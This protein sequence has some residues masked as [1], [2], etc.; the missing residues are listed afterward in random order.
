MLQYLICILN[1]DLQEKKEFIVERIEKIIASQGKYSRSEV[2]KLIGKNKVEVDGQV[3]KSSGIKVDPD[4]SKITLDGLDIV[5]KK[6]VYLILNKPKGYISARVD[7]DHQT[8]LDLVPKELLGRNLFPVGR[9]DRDTTGLI[10][11]TDDGLLA[12]NI[13]SPKKHVN[14]IYHVKLDIPVSE[15]MIWGFARGVELN[16]GICKEASLKITGKHTASVTLSEG[17]HHQIKRMFG[18]FGAKV[19]ELHRVS[20]G[21]LTLP[22]DLQEGSCRELSEEELKLLQQL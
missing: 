6:F 13:L 16:D 5:Y 14:K 3:V 19:T 8:V 1:G 22:A 10:I 11:I 17:R 12:H 18:C 2:K 4:K 20:M 9:L 21:N 7:K 15:D